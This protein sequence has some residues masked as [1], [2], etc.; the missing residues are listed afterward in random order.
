M[1]SLFWCEEDGFANLGGGNKAA[2]ENHWFKGGRCTCQGVVKQEWLHWLRMVVQIQNLLFLQEQS[3]VSINF[4]TKQAFIWILNSQINGSP[5]AL[6]KRLW[7]LAWEDSHSDWSYSVASWNCHKGL[8]T[9]D[10]HLLIH[11]RNLPK[12]RSFFSWGSTWRMWVFR[13]HSWRYK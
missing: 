6:L 10:P 7:V 4:L 2:R 5:F 3:G 11:I 12:V 9:K 1:F 13:G 8:I